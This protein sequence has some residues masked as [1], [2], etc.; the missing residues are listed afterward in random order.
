LER[1]PYELKNLVDD[2]AARGI[3]EQMEK[4]LAEWME[5]SEDRW[6]YNWET[7]WDGSVLDRYQTFYTFDEYLEWAAEHPDLR[8]H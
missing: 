1:D 8:G 7:P 6:N 2:P 4:E 3:R 5:R